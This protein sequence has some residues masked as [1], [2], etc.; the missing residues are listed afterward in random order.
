M[1]IRDICSNIRD[2]GG[3]GTFRTLLGKGLNL[4][5]IEL[6]TGTVKRLLRVAVCYSMNSKT[7]INARTKRNLL[8]TSG[9]SPRVSNNCAV[10]ARLFK[11][12]VFIQ[13]DILL[14]Y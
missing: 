14:N 6:K 4:G 2:K 5:L 13:Y 10:S 11:V 9:R 12:L 8:L 3:L 1:K 7:E